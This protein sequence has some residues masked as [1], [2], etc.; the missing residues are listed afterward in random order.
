MVTNFWSEVPKILISTFCSEISGSTGVI[1][2]KFSA[3]IATY[4]GVDD[5]PE[6]RF[7]IVQSRDVA[8]V[9]NFGGRISKIPYP[10][11]IK[12]TSIHNCGEFSIF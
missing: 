3:L 11:C 10:T 12:C 9:T 7:A 2:S 8:I 5:R 4:V 1:F 6:I